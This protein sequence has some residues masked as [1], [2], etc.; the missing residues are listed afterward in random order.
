MKWVESVPNFSVGR[1]SEGVAR[2]ASA[3][4][5]VSGAYLLHVDPEYDTNRCVMTVIGEPEAVGEAVFLAVREAMQCIDMNTHTGS[6]PRMGATDVLPF[7]PWSGISTEECVALAHEVGARIGEELS[8]PGWFYGAAR[9]LDSNRYLHDIR[10][11]QF[12]GLPRKL[13]RKVVDFGPQQPHPT[14][15][16]L[17]VGVR[18]ILVAMN[19]TLDSSDV[20]VAR[21]IAAQL[22]EFQ[23]VRLNANG[24]VEERVSVG[25]PGLRALGWYS[26]RD[27]FSQV[28]MNLTD[29][30]Q[31]P[32]HRVFSRLLALV[33]EG[34]GR[35]LGTELVGMIP[36][37]LL[38]E[39]GLHV[40][41]NSRNL[42][43]DGMRF[44]RLGEMHPFVAEERIIERCLDA[45][46]ILG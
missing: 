43:S 32:P 28:T 39:A 44:L 35:I 10:R 37:K 30:V 27:G 4:D 7:V 46:G 3:L 14:A 5:S 17:A 33:E 29:I 8:L 41:P 45:R 12:E 42:L 9:R 22:R 23:Q 20:R 13:E 26:D 18:P 34:G 40:E 6:H 15:G 24:G 11:G 2:I 21:S 38:L 36:E 19:C 31:S 16:A 1:D 25:I